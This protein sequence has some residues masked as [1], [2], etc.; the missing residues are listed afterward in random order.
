M[1]LASTIIKNKENFVLLAS[2]VGYAKKSWE[3][4][5]LPGVQVNKHKVVSS[6]KWIKSESEK[7]TCIEAIANHDPG[8]KPHVIEL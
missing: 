1:G 5:I 8:M 7:P 2:D 6:L 3:Q 4:M